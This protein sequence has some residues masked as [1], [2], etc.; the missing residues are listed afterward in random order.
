MAQFTAEKIFNFNKINLNFFY[1]HEVDTKFQNNADF[2]AQG[3]IYNDGYGIKAK[4][5]SDLK[6]LIAGGQDLTASSGNVPTGGTVE[7]LGVTLDAGSPVLW[8]IERTS[9]GFKGL[10]QAMKTS[11]NADDLSLFSK[12]LSGD[13]FVNLSPGAD[14]FS[15]FAGNDI[16]DGKDGNDVLFGNVGNDSIKGS[17]GNDNLN[18]GAGQDTLRGGVGNDKLNGGADI[19]TLRGGAGNDVFIV[20]HVADRAYELVGEGDDTVISSVSYYLSQNIETLVLTGHGA[21]KGIGNTIAN[22]IIGNG[23]NNFLD[24]LGGV[25][26]LKGGAGNDTY[27][28]DTSFDKVIDSSGIDTILTRVSRSLMNYLAI[29]KLV[30]FGNHAI[31]GTGNSLN[32][33]ITGNIGKNVLDGGDGDDVLKGGGGQD[34]LTGGAG[35]DRYVFINSDF[36]GI[37]DPP[38][39]STFENGGMNAGTSALIDKIDLSAVGAVQSFADIFLIENAGSH[40]G[41]VLRWFGN[42]AGPSGAIEVLANNFPYAAND[43][44]F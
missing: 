13:D 38:V 6:F 10:Y 15:G 16:I 18:G 32:N 14:V 29:E 27:V 31:D 42:A 26:I 40:G 28:L 21:T 34:T 1:A 36:T 7:F 5:G 44:I 37:L 20:D 25:D 23:A 33:V 24:G 9:V 35:N 12:A 8:A 19:D 11:S 43:F 17:L 30:L 4:D 39:I 22:T 3:T 41:D 2:I